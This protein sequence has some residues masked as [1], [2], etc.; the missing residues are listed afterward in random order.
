ME[1][2]T[3]PAAAQL[4]TGCIQNKLGQC[5][6]YIFG[7]RT[8]TDRFS[9]FRKEVNTAET[10]YTH[11]D[12]VVFSGNA[13]QNG[14]NDIANLIAERSGNAISVTILLHR[15]TDLSTGQP[16]QQYFFDKILRHAQRLC[17]DKTAPPYL[18]AD[19]IPP[20][21]EEREKAYW[22][23]CV[24]V[25]QFSIHAAAESPHLDV[26]LC[27]TALLNTACVQM[28]LG[29]IRLNLGYTPNEFGLNYLLNLCG[30]FTDLPAKLFHKQTPDAIRR[31]KML[32]APPSLLNHWTKL[33]ARE[34]DFLWLLDAVQQ[35]LG[36]SKNLMDD[37]HP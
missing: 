7:C 10:E 24:A 37:R 32:C 1:P 8:D 28:A 26:E 15:R 33:N 35:F 29:L 25:A 20:R 34:S 31:Y 18:L 36:L 4:I 5:S 11:F 13:Y 14:A 12:I 16:N 23:K 2:L 9:I 22:L 19:T 3:T 30:S 21:D 27:K 17:L 6:A